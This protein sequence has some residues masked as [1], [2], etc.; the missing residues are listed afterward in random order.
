[1]VLVYT[2]ILANTKRLLASG[3]FTVFIK[4]TMQLMLSIDPVCVSCTNIIS[5]SL[6]SFMIQLFFWNMMF[7]LHQ[8]TGQIRHLF[9]FLLLANEVW[10]KA[11]FLHLSVSHSV[12]RGV[13]IQGES[14]SRGCLHPDG[15]WAG[16]PWKLRYTVNERA[17]RIL[18]ESILVSVLN[19]KI[20]LI[21]FQKA[22]IYFIYGFSEV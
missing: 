17:V 2:M 12:D 13:C 20:H 4:G 6:S 9:E 1:M 16:N 19:K 14:A 15:G 3:W 10:G 22:F 7:L 11:I 21:R 5:I 8:V 18:W